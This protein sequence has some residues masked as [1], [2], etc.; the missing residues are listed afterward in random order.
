MTS[1]ALASTSNPAPFNTNFYVVAATVIPVLFLAIAVQGRLQ[2]DMLQA[3]INERRRRPGLP[4]Y[5]GMPPWIHGISMAVT[6]LCMLTGGGAEGLAVL[7]LWWQ[8][9]PPHEFG[10]QLVLVSTLGLACVAGM[11]AVWVWA[12]PLLAFIER[13]GEPSSDVPEEPPPD[14][15]EPGPDYDVL[16]R[17]PKPEP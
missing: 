10:P 2:A 1:I 7:F 12:M 14:P 4:V 8:H 5:P 16:F 13:T 9:V 6:C 3:A 15:D 11:G 17:R